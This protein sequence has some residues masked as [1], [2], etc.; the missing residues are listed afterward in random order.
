MSASERWACRS[1]TRYL[2]RRLLPT[3][4]DSSVTSASGISATT[5]SLPDS[6][7][8]LSESLRPPHSHR[9]VFHATDEPRIGYYVLPRRIH[10][11][12]VFAS[13][14]MRQCDH[15]PGLLRRLVPWRPRTHPRLFHAYYSP[16]TQGATQPPSRLCGLRIGE[17]GSDVQRERGRAKVNATGRCDR[18]HIYMPSTDDSFLARDLA[19]LALQ[20]LY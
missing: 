7:C 4:D 19:S 13:H 9:L 11:P 5:S 16:I 3:P 8:D 1:E 20:I 15:D 18:P 17:G 2:F 10:V 14:C 6:L 12:G